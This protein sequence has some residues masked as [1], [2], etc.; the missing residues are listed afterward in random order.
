MFSQ[1]KWSVSDGIQTAAIPDEL[2]SL[3]WMILEGPSIKHKTSGRNNAANVLLQ[4]LIFNGVKFNTSDSLA[5][6]HNTDRETPVPT[7]LGLMLHGTTRKRDLVDK[8][9]VLGL[10][11]SYARVLQISSD[12][13]NTVC[14]LH[15]AEGV[16]CPPHLR[17]N[18]FT[19]LAVDNIDHNQQLVI[20][21]MEWLS[22]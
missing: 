7:Y 6:R 18:I 12:F 16:V 22:H 11:V 5:V 10:S 17:K 13:A 2:L 19:T 1:I 3:V 8:L 9:H 20:Y 14:R 15:E 4:I 21:F